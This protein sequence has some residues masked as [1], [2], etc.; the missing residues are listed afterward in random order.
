MKKF[1]KNSSQIIKGTVSI[2]LLYLIF[3]K[4]NLSQSLGY[5][6][7]VN[8]F[9]LFFS[10]GL[11]LIHA[12]LK[13]YKW[14]LLINTENSKVGTYEAM[15]SYM[16]GTAFA[17]VTP[18][19]IGEL[20]R[21]SNLK[22]NKLNLGLLVVADKVVELLVVITFA[23]WG[24][25]IKFQNPITLA[26]L[27]ACLLLG[28]FFLFNLKKLDKLFPRI[29]KISFVN[30]VINGLKLVS[31]R[32]LIEVFIFSFLTMLVFFLQAYLLLL[33]F[34]FGNLAVVFL[35]FPLILLTNLIPITIGG[36]GVREG[37]ASILL[38]FYGVPVSISVVV[39]LFLYLFDTIIPG[40]FGSI[41]FLFKNKENQA[42]EV[43]K[44]KYKNI[45]DV[46]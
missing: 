35:V 33:S 22:G 21:I 17:I 4:I 16:R 10:F 8:Y 14:K 39:A 6:S 24:I 42:S 41:A 1:I 45:Q 5:L 19:R 36:F 38:G 32:I 23:V 2:V 9:Y 37:S 27:I 26:I 11:I 40:I 31:S 13:S 12:Y 7:N 46:S 28:V 30:K 18:A 3:R 15:L 43:E 29:A 34:G 44:N 20:M 25:Y